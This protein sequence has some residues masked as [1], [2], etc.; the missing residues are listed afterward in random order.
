MPPPAAAA[1]APAVATAAAPPAAPAAAA[2]VPAAATSAAAA[3]ARFESIFAIVAAILSADVVFP[4]SAQGLTLVHMS[5][6][7]EALLAGHAGCFRVPVIKTTQ[8]DLKSGRV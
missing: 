4:A 1:P 8:V 6:S 7:H 5:S 2:A 3:A